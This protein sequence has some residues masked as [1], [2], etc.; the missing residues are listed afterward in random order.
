MKIVVVT[1]ANTGIGAAFAREIASPDTQIWLACRSEQ[2]TEPVRQALLAQAADARFLRLDLANLT[3]AQ[4][5]ARV[6]AEA[7]PRIDL[8]VNNAGLAGAR[9]L[10]AQGFELGFGTNHL[11]HFAFTLPLLPALAAARGRVVVVSSNNHYLAKSLD[12][13]VVRRPTQSRTGLSEYAVSKLANV[14]FAA[15][16]RRRHPK[17]EAVSL[18]PGRIASDIWRRV[19]QPFRRVLPWLLRMGSV[20]EGGH[21]LAHA[22]SVSLADGALYLDKLA[23]RTP[24][25]LAADPDL[26]RKLWEFSEEAVGQQQTSAHAA[27]PDL[28]G[29]S[30]SRPVGGLQ[31]EGAAQHKTLVT[32][33]RR[34]FAAER[35]SRGERI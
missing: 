9:G 11:G 30:A 19:P 2:K 5:A 4:H 33:L 34:G 27:P 31:G 20:E 3:S 21:T 22:A 32:Q 6:L 15:E 12:L 1:G 8:L 13:T 14:L 25:K 17:I 7:L 26:A 35:S 24:S 23:P 16:L 10:T 29:R 18:H 28:P